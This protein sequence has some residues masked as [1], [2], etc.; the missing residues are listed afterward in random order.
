MQV[1]PAQ[2]IPAGLLV[3]E[4]LPGPALVL[5]VSVIGCCAAAT[6]A[7]VAKAKKVS[8]KVGTFFIMIYRKRH[9]E[10]CIKE[11]KIIALVQP[12]LAASGTN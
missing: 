4:P 8:V 5:T 9:D 12:N 11:M 2:A 3:T 7:K 6:P 1:A 10:I